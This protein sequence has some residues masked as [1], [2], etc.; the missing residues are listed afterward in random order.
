MAQEVI[1]EGVDQHR[2]D[3]IVEASKGMF[4]VMGVVQHHDAITGTDN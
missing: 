1:R 4:D 3:D 2:V